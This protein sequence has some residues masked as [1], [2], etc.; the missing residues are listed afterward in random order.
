MASV[1]ENDVRHV[2]ALARVGLDADRVQQLVRELNGILA[3]MDVLAR[4]DTSQTAPFVAEQLDAMP[5][6][7]DVEGQSTPL[8]APFVTIAPEMRDGFFLVPRLATHAGD[9]A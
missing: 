4:V 2:A 8:N 1:S 6:R 3:H 5:L 9:G 7:P